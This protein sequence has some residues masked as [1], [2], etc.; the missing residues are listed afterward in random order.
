M[1]FYKQFKGS[2]KIEPYVVQILNRNQRQWLCRYCTSMHNLQIEFRRY[3]RPVTLILE[4]KCKYCKNNSLDDEGHFILFYETFRLKCQCFIG[5]LNML[6]PDFVLMSSEEKL[7]FIL[8]PPTLVI[9]KCVSKFL[10]I[11]TKVRSE[12]YMGLITQDLN[13]YIKHVANKN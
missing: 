2:F 10:G 1:R 13:L 3:T 8:C 12:I 9:A 11:M 6:N 4:R 5:R 7:R